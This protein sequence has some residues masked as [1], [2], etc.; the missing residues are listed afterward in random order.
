[1]RVVPEFQETSPFRGQRMRAAIEQ[2]VLQRLFV[3]GKLISLT[4][5][6]IRDDGRVLPVVLVK[7]EHGNVWFVCERKDLGL[8]QRQ[9]LDVRR[10]QRID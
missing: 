10:I 6:E 4:I 7:Y 2:L 1:M 5:G 9:S 3:S 8:F